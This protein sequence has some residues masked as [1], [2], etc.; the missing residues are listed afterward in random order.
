VLTNILGINE[1]SY[2]AVFARRLKA[3]AG[4]AFEFRRKL[5]SRTNLPEHGE[6]ALQGF[7]AL[8]IGI[9]LVEN[10]GG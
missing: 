2:F 4:E 5:G 6:L 9:H 3:E 7:M 1:E 10:S 8:S